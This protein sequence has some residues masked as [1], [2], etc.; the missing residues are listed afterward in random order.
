[1]RA[2]EKNE[3]WDEVDLPR[4]KTTVGCKW[5]FTVKYNSNGSLERYKARF[6]AKG[7]T[8]TYGIDY[9]ETFSPV[10]KLNTVRVLLSIAVNLDWPLHQLDVKNAFLNGELAE[11]AYMDAPPGFSERFGSSVCRLKRSL[12]GLKRSPRGWFE[13][14]AKFVKGQGF[15]QGQADHT[16]FMKISSEGKIVVLIVYVDDIILTGDDFEEMSK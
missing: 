11:E 10:A 6:V 5:V 13:R 16:L 1:M 7:F 9:S 8:Q 14:F 4:G 12:Y 15:T 3:T 2:L